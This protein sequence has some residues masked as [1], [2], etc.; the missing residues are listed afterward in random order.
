MLMTIDHIKPKRQLRRDEIVAFFAEYA[1]DHHNAPS[2]REI[3]YA[4]GIAQQTVYRHLLKLCE[5]GRMAQLDGKFKLTDARYI[6][7]P[8]DVTPE[9]QPVKRIKARKNVR[10]EPNI[11]LMYKQ[12]KGLCWWCGAELFGVFEVDHR[13][14]VAKGGTD[15]IGNLCLS[16]HDCNSKKSDQTPGE[17]NGR[18]L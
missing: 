18:L 12:Q 11:Q 2:T 6:P 17:F 7:P 5:E 13:L 14:A 10:T 15:D 4:L 9:P 3:A 1:V 8:E 16:C